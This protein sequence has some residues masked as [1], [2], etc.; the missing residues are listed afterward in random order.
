MS[1]EFNRIRDSLKQF[2]FHKL[3][4]NELGWSQPVSRQE[5]P[6]TVKD[7][8]FVRRQIAELAGVVVFEVFAEDGK[9]PDAKM[10][11]AVH[12]E[13]AKQHHENVLL[14]VDHD[15]TQS[16][17]YWV[18]RQDGKTI[19]RDHLYVKGQPGDL[20]LSKLSQIVFDIG[21]FDAQG[22]ISIVEVAGRLRA[23]LDIEKVTKRFYGEFHDQHLDFL[24][25]IRG[26]KDERQ[27]RWYA[28]VLLNRLM[29]IYF[30]QKKRFVDNGDVNYLQNK[31][32][33]SQEKGKNKF[34][35]E[36]LTMLFFEGFAKPEEKRSA[37]ARKEL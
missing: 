8:S 18:K 1:I 27:R 14:F 35:S 9:I 33:A 31:L 22:N 12:K 6:F 16:L 34:F 19:P 29:F 28:S 13:I 7:A 2:D 36:F 32:A 23:A 11:A 30:L 25:L 4:V 24:N 37:E 5:S 17:W 3:F 10:R 21:D 20:F 26:V 15:R